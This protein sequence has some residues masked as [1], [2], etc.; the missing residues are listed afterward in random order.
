MSVPLLLRFDTYFGLNFKVGPQVSF[1]LTQV[2]DT[3]KR[4]GESTSLDADD[5]KVPDS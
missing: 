4:L 3:R 5:F 1:L 2:G